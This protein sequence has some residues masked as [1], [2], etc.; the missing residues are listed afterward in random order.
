MLPFERFAAW[1]ACHQ[2]ALEVYALTRGWP[3]AERYGLT[4]Q[5]RNAAVSAASNIAEG[6]TKRGKSE[7]RRYLDIS[8]G[9]LSEVAYRL[10]L[11][12]DVAILDEATWNQ[13]NGV[14][15]TASRLTWRLYRSMR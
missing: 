1:R 12:R 5:V 3:K 10:M 6:S 9:S 8:L 11:A 4:A 15:E 2:L 7:F 14:R 13:V